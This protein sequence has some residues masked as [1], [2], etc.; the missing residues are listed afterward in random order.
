MISNKCS[1]AHT[2]QFNPVTLGLSLLDDAQSE[3]LHSFLDTKHNLEDALQSIFN[4]HSEAFEATIGAHSQFNNTLLDTAHT[5]HDTRYALKEARDGLDVRRQDLRMLWTKG[6]KLKEAMRILDLIEGVR[7]VPERLET[8]I[9]EKR[10]IEAVVLLNKSLRVVNMPS[11]SGVGAIVDLRLFLLSH[12]NA[13]RELL[14]E[15][16]H[17]HVYLKTHHADRRWRAYKPSSPG[18]DESGSESE[19]R[20]YLTKLSRS[21]LKDWGKVDDTL[22]HNSIPSPNL[23]SP[24]PSPSVNMSMENLN[25]SA[26]DHHIP[27]PFE[28]DNYDYIQTLLEALH[29]LH[30]LPDVLDLLPQRIPLEIQSLISETVEQV[31]ARSDRAR[32]NTSSNHTAQSAVTAGIISSLF[33]DTENVQKARE[34]DLGAHLLRD[35]LHTLF[36][37]LD[38][39]LRGLRVVAAVVHK[40]DATARTLSL[41]EMWRL[42]QR[43][44][45]TLIQGYLIREDGGRATNLVA[46]I[47]DVLRQSGGARDRT[48]FLFRFAET[49]GKAMARNLKS[50]EEALSNVLSTTMPGLV[51]AGTLYTNLLDSNSALTNEVDKSYTR[52]TKADAFNIPVLF[53]PTC[54]FIKSGMRILGMNGDDERTPLSELRDFMDTFIEK[55][56]LPQLQD[57][58][59]EL[60]QGAV[61]SVDAFAEETDRAGDSPKP[62]VKVG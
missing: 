48:K 13:L 38:A 14:I 5:I 10:W 50:H 9:S 55:V 45:Q 4:S 60:F 44:V 21:T 53:Q 41:A 23:H 20:S 52:L 51:G 1:T 2:V 42:V 18:R 54:A 11:L 25:M 33:R 61:A 29:V 39:V 8:L 43:E 19:F 7:V 16:L 12:E 47:N 59:M 31:G 40:L 32:K 6:D 26:G 22:H 57:K 28:S 27:T 3:A 56:F 15:E 62:V 37:K 49:D 34:L 58:V 46:S 30:R 36:S 17:S 24:I 35:L